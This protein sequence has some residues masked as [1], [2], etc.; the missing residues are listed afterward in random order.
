MKGT[1]STS[2]KMSARAIPKEKKS[3]MLMAIIRLITLL[4][5]YI[6]HERVIYSGEIILLQSELSFY[7]YRKRMF[8]SFAR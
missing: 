5:N 8:C 7:K 3:T 4:P 2:S 1:Y 6:F